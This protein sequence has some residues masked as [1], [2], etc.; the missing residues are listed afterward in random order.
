MNIEMLKL[1]SQNKSQVKLT[2]LSE[3]STTDRENMKQ[4]VKTRK[5]SKK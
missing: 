2:A 4:F 5:S 3:K 1:R